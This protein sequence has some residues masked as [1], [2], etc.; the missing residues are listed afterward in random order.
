MFTA[1]YTPEQ[2]LFPL[3]VILY[4]LCSQPTA[5]H[6]GAEVGRRIDWGKKVEFVLVCDTRNAEKYA[7][8]SV[9]FC[10]DCNYCFLFFIP[11][12][13]S[14]DAE[15]EYILLLEWTTVLLLLLRIVF[16]SLT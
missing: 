12:N 8:C 4:L 16:H 5:A 13:K 15:A 6:M 7:I 1:H 3:F 14:V 9:K 2:L 10:P 11:L